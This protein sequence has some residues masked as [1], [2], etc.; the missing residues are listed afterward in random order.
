MRE[1]VVGVRTVVLLWMLEGSFE[2][3]EEW[4]TQLKKEIK[5]EENV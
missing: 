3:F 4:A 1:K 2:L 5:Q